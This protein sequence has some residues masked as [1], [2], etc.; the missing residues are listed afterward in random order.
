MSIAQQMQIEDLAKRVQILEAA[1]MDEGNYAHL[2][3]RV[4]KLEG[5][6]RALKARM[7]KKP[8]E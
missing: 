6:L 1:K 4:Q 7:G 2:A 5:E 8:P 3:E